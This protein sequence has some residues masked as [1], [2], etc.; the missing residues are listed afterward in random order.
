MDA[1]PGDEIFISVFGRT[2]L[3]ICVA[4]M[5]VVVW[6]VLAGGNFLTIRSSA[7]ILLVAVLTLLCVARPDSNIGLLLVV[8]IGVYW[9]ITVDHR[10]NFWTL[11]AAL[12]LLLV[13]TSLAASTT[14]PVDRPSNATRDRW[15]RRT[16]IVGIVTAGVW[17]VAYAFSQVTSPRSVLLSALSFVVLCA[18]ALLVR[19][20]TRT[21]DPPKLNSS[22]ALA[23]PARAIDE[24]NRWRY[25]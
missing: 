3:L 18:I 9:A 2:R 14:S 6:S 19:A 25:G 11:P 5:L 17:V 24:R 20:G 16:A 12:S 1:L 21:G 23:D 13:H 22:A 10:L 4:P 8:V 15:T 7:M